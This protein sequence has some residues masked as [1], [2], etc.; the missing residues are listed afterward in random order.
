MHASNRVVCVVVDLFVATRN[1]HKTAEFAQILGPEFV[2]RDLRTIPEAVPVEETGSTFEEN[3]ILKALA[4]AAIVPGVVVADDSGLEVDAL[5]GAPGVYSAR[6][7]G[8]GAPDVENVNKLLRDLAVVERTKPERMARFCCALAVARGGEVLASF[9]ATSEGHI[10]HAPAGVSGFGYDPVFVPQGYTRTFA[11]L[12]P[13]VKNCL[14]HRAKAIA[15][16]REYL[17]E[18]AEPL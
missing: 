15:Q 5:N 3:A 14:S 9:T 13:D 2:V 6:Y 11:E 1:A 12:G 8:S 18:L 16:L 10:S 17:R 4:A 7:A